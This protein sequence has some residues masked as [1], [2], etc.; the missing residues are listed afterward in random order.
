LEKTGP[1]KARPITVVYGMK[2]LEVAET[3]VVMDKSTTT[4]VA[5]TLFVERLVHS[6]E[7]KV[8]PP[9]R[10]QVEGGVEFSLTSLIMHTKVGAKFNQNHFNGIFLV[11]GKYHLAE[12]YGHN[13]ALSVPSVQEIGSY[14]DL[15][16]SKPLQFL[17]KSNGRLEA[18]L[19]KKKYNQQW[20]TDATVYVYTRTLDIGCSLSLSLSLYLSI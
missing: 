19:S 13:E 10:I 11:D 15:I 5:T 16:S 14:Q 9:Q 8:T 20:V 12:N 18:I 1:F 3:L 2:S 17:N 4:P 6:L 7:P